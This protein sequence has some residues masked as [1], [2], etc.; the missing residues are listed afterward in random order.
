MSISF[1]HHISMQNVSDFEALWIW[2][3]WIRYIQPICTYKRHTPIKNFKIQVHIL[4]TTRLCNMN[5][6]YFI[7][8]YGTTT[9]CLAVSL[10]PGRQ[11]KSLTNLA[12]KLLCKQIVTRQCQIFNNNNTHT[13]QRSCGYLCSGILWERGG[14]LVIYKGIFEMGTEK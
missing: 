13:V 9:R 12:K 7:N 5:G 2:S 11:N 8:I 10:V 1:Q 4:S 14:S 3:F 6:I